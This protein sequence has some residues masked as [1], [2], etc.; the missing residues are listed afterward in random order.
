MPWPAR[1]GNRRAIPS[2]VIDMSDVRFPRLLGWRTSGVRSIGLLAAVIV[3]LASCAGGE[4]S[5]LSEA[6]QRG[7]DLSRAS[8]CAGCHG[9]DGQGGVGPAWI[10]LAGSDVE[11]TDGTTVVAD[12]DYLIRS[13]VDPGAE[14]VAGFAIR[15]PVAGALDEADVADVVAYIKELVSEPAAGSGQP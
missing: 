13:I 3:A 14:E 15:M 9:V 4:A 6:A 8:G 11:L 5:N 7:R 12:D 2:D 1:Y 10:D